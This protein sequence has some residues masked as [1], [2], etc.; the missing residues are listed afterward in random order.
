M[1]DFRKI[2][3][4][5]NGLYKSFLFENPKTGFKTVRKQKINTELSKNKIYKIDSFVKKAKIIGDFGNH[6]FLKYID[7]ETFANFIHENNIEKSY[8]ILYNLFQ[9]INNQ[10]LRQE[11]SEKNLIKIFDLIQEKLTSIESYYKYYK[12][13]ENFINKNLENLVDFCFSDNH[14]DFNLNNII[15]DEHEVAHLIDFHSSFISCREIDMATLFMD[16]LFGWSHHTYREYHFTKF[17]RL[18]LIERFIYLLKNN[19]YKIE[20]IFCF[21]VI[22]LIRILPYCDGNTVKTVFIYDHLYNLNKL[23]FS[24]NE[25]AEYDEEFYLD[26]CRKIIKI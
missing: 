24:F 18:K 23:L 15:I 26:L 3:L 21:C 25:K 5:G 4:G 16:L 7:G 19:G 22:N 1:S 20:T 12:N 9:N 13:I 2:E 11:H 8:E 17:K 6:Y 10:T 14:G